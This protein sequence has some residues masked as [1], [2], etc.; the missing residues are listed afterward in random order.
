MFSN[1]LLEKKKKKRSLLKI[2]DF[3]RLRQ[4]PNPQYYVAEVESE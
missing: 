3:S 1:S 4:F 2:K